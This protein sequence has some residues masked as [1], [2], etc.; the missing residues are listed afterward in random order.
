MAV[1]GVDEPV[2]GPVV[3]GVD[4][5]RTSDVAV[6]FALREA[7][8][9]GTDLLAVHGLVDPVSATV[10]DPDRAHE[11]VAERLARLVER[12]PEVKECND[13][14][15]PLEVKV[16][17]EDVR[18]TPGAALA[19]HA[20]GAQLVVVGSSRRIGKRGLVLRST[21]QHVLHR[22]PCPVAVVSRDH[23]M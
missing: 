20:A 15:A 13:G 3:V 9:R 17:Q 10:L 2:A 5:T 16:T 22:A 4:G 7:S 21:G 19:E 6:D 12:Y 1:V 8:L 14:P 18:N 23:T 11:L